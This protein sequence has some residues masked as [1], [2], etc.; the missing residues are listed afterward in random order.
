[1]RVY[2][3]T[4]D[5]HDQVPTSPRELAEISFV[6]TPDETRKIAAFLLHAADEMERMGPAYGHLHLS[7]VQK[8]FDGSPH[9]TVF[10]TVTV[11]SMYGEP[12]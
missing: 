10:N 4:E 3:H 5:E 2:G 7:D 12:A 1:M 8:S 6:V 9:V 11:E